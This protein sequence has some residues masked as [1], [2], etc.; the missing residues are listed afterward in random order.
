LPQ[1][2]GPLNLSNVDRVIS[3]VHVA[4]LPP[5]YQQQIAKGIVADDERAAMSIV[6]RLKDQVCS[7]QATPTP[8]PTTAPTTAPTGAA[9]PT[10]APSPGATTIVPPVTATSPSASADGGTGTAECSEDLDG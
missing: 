4:D 2:I 10:R 8:T 1:D 6:D 5:F 9:S 3:D 7:Q